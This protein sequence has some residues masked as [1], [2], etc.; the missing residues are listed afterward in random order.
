MVSFGQIIQTNNEGCDFYRFR[1]RIEIPETEWIEK[2]S[3]KAKNY[4]QS[5]FHTHTLLN[6]NKSKT[7]NGRT[8]VIFNSVNFSK[9]ENAQ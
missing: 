7:L 2:E 8:V 5:D 4:H 1:E 3:S 9:H 6:L